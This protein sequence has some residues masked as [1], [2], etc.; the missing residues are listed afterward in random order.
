MRFILFF[1]IFILIAGCQQQT[2]IT[3]SKPNII[4]LLVDDVGWGDFSPYG[5]QFH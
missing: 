5:A 2:D 4:V 3:Q 1:L